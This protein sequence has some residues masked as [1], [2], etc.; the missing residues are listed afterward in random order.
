MNVDTG[1]IRKLMDFSKTE[2]KSGKIVPLEDKEAE[3]LKPMNRDERRA[4]A[5]GNTDL[6]EQRMTELQ[7]MQAD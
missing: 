6:L 2:L 3:E 1:E 5:K 4:W 7:K